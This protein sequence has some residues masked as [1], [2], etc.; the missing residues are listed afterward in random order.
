MENTTFD[1][2]FLTAYLEFGN[3]PKPIPCAKALASKYGEFIHTTSF[4]LIL[5][6]YKRNEKAKWNG[7]IW[8]EGKIGKE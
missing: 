8:G 2:V 6:M 1:V 7:I 4:Q 3:S 5:Q